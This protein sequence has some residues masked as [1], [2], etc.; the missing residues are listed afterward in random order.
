M[1]SENGIENG[2]WDSLAGRAKPLQHR[3]IGPALAHFFWASNP[4]QRG[5]VTAAR[6]SLFILTV[7]CATQEA[8]QGN[9][10]QQKKQQDWQVGIPLHAPRGLCACSQKTRGE[11]FMPD[12]TR[13][14]H[15][16][17]PPSSSFRRH[18]EIMVPEG[19]R[20]LTRTYLAYSSAHSSTRLRPPPHL[21]PS[22]SELQQQQQ[23]WRL[24][25]R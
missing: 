9:M 10:T 19:H 6:G 24:G 12:C 20:V 7:P 14:H 2:I 21:F 22:P 25:R 17:L 11:S 23:R 16:S 18:E 5:N 3:A 13:G 1:L 15:S 8:A 4:Q